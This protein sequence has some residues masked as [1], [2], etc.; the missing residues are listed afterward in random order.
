M[1]ESAY[2]DLSMSAVQFGEG[3][4]SYGDDDIGD[5]KTFLYL[6]PQKYQ[7]SVNTQQIRHYGSF[8]N[9]MKD[10]VYKMSITMLA[11]IKIKRFRTFNY[12]PTIAVAFDVNS[13]K[14]GEEVV[15]KRHSHKDHE[16]SNHNH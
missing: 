16:H 5:I 15:S 6:P 12:L 10:M 3:M 8:W 4:E 9:K 14:S 2:K 1:T 11:M 7:D 13:Q